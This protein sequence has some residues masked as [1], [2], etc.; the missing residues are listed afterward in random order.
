V[1]GGLIVAMKMDSSITVAR[2]GQ[3]YPKEVKDKC[4]EL[5]REG[6]SI[7]EVVKIISEGINI[8][9][10]VNYVKRNYEELDSGLFK[11]IKGE[12]QVFRPNRVFTNLVKTEVIPRFSGERFGEGLYDQRYST[13]CSSM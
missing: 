8:S 7:E 5:L 4:I 10:I 3:T 12:L 1:K 11:E 6:K 2:E 9:N 13:K